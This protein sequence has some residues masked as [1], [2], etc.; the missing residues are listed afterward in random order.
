[1]LADLCP[2]CSRFSQTGLD[3]RTAA[4]S[5]YIA[6]PN[7]QSTADLLAVEERERYRNHHN[8][9]TCLPI[10]T[11]Y[12]CRKG[13]EELVAQEEV[14]AVDRQYVQLCRDDLEVEYS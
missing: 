9:R 14:D 4:C 7:T 8:E 2:S 10:R 11:R 13:L 6:R 5:N 12:Q 1:M 3:E